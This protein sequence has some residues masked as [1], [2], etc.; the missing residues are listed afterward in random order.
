MQEDLYT[1]LRK[2]GGQARPNHC[3]SI[4]KTTVTVLICSKVFTDVPKIPLLEPSGII[5]KILPG[6]EGNTQIYFDTNCVFTREMT[7]NAAGPVNP[8]IRP[9]S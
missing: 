8:R 7:S 2:S 6:I 1:V 9:A 3:P 4:V 5:K